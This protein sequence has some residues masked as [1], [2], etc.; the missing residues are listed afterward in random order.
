MAKGDKFEKLMEPGYIGRVRTRNRII[1]TA[2][3]TGLIE[4]DG[5]VGETMRD[6]Y[7]TMA[8]GGVGLLIYEYCSV[9]YPR[10]M[11]RPTCTAHL[12][13]D[14]FIP[15][16]SKMVEA[17][18]KHGCPFFTQLMHS[19]PWYQSVFWNEVTDAPG[20]R[21]GPSTITAE[22]LPPGLFTPV[23]E[24]S[25][26]EIE[27][28]IE[29][30]GKAAERAQK[31]GFD[32]IEI[33]GSHYHLINTFFSP[34]WNRRHD[35]YGCDSLENRARFM[36]NIIRETKRA[37][38][39]DYPITA[40]FNAVE[41]GVESATTLDDAKGFAR[42]LEAAGAD[43][44]QVRAAGYGP[45]SGILHV[46]RFFYPELPEELK[47]KELDWR[48]KG[49]GIVVPLGSAI[50]EVV[51]IPVFL[52]SRLDP[53]LGESLLEQ[54]KLDF[55]GMTRRLFADPELPH[56]VAQGRLEDIAPC[57]GCNY[58]WHIRAYVD[59]PL[60]CR[61]N[62]ALGRH[63]EFEIKPAE[64]KKRVL[65]A[66]GGP[67]GLEAARVAALRGHDVTLYE[68]ERTFGGLMPL[69]AMVKEHELESILSTIQ[70]LKTQNT[71]LGVTMRRG[72][73]V[74][75]SA[76]NEIR[77]DVLILATGGDPAVP[78][79]RGIN[80]PKVVNN[81]NL[82]RTLKF[83]MRFVGPKAMERLTKLWMPIGK[84]VV[85]IGGG[86]EGCQ[87]AEFL[88]KRGRKV[89]IVDSEPTLGKG[90][91]SDDPDRLF[92]WFDKKGVV[93]TTGVT[94]EAVS[95]EG[96]IV[97]TKEGERKTLMADSI[98]TALPLRPAGD[99]AESLGKKVTEVYEIGDC[100]EPGHMYDAI[101]D[102]YRIGRVI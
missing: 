22:Q 75:A 1:K 51:S 74:D 16:Y 39:S 100:R 2:A 77:P 63:R 14:R 102:G 61:I 98:I 87:L 11:L 19:G 94:Y 80:H 83:W 96:L 58:C 48:R 97:T 56:K 73:A 90:L 43:A 68:K 52:A 76:I 21:V 89:T 65:I 64:K 70:Y 49:K 5:I 32:G 69:A 50:K 88:V 28:L 101:A 66:G 59:S 38:G 82:H 9:E 85:I 54:G 31:I 41:Y 81:A 57:S 78:A 7:E 71:K 92:K 13:D 23:R 35:A 37:C 36:C 62:A 84:I 25:I 33:N 47:V 86:L 3:G 4:K 8:K 55:I 24:L 72:K 29:L 6:F 91:L 40:L 99:L 44:I 42:L 15:S 46:D 34:F 10:G 20:D 67:S 95:D 53:E 27:G 18:H 79:I 26:G 93:T 60:R 12:S 45:F 30:F 17:V